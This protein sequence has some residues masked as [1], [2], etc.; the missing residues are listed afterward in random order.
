[1][2]TVTWLPQRHVDARLQEH[3]H[4]LD[5]LCVHI[6]EVHLHIQVYGLKS[7][8]MADMYARV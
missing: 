6:A 7:A 2:Q 4:I 5:S 8:H 3:T 1:M